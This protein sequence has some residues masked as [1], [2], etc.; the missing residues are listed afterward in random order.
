[1]HS[2]DTAGQ[3][4]AGIAWIRKHRDAAAVTQLLEENPRRILQGELP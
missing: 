2:P 4:A 1:M 3:I